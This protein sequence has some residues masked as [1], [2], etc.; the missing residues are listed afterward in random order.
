RI[1]PRSAQALNNL[2]NLVYKEGRVGEARALYE[3]ALEIRPGWPLALN[4][5]GNAL[6]SLGR[7][8]EAIA[9]YREALAHEALDSSR[10]LR[11]ILANAL[12]TVLLRQGRSAEAVAVLEP[13]A[14]QDD[15][16]VLATLA[17]AYL[18]QDDLVRADETA[19]RALSLAV[20][21]DLRAVIERQLAEIRRRRFPHP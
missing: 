13:V 16:H 18:V 19:V 12:G 10:S 15:A 3:R 4:N 1:R 17:A 7:P 21:P 9:R 11:T 2:G 5:L 14:G 20:D 8:D 6:R